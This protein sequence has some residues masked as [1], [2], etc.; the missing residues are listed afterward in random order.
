MLNEA[1]KV[2]L[3]RLKKFERSISSKKGKIEPSHGQEE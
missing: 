3:L 2:R 1:E